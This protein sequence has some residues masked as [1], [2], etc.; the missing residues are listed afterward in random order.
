MRTP[1]S[2]SLAT[3]P[4]RL[5]SAFCVVAFV[6]SLFAARLVQLQG[7]DENDYAAM[8]RATG[9]ETITLEAPRAPIY[10]RFGN[11]LAES[12]DALKL[13]ADPT[14][15]RAHA[16]TIGAVLHRRLGADYIDTVALLRTPNTRYIELARHLLPQAATATV[17]R[18][19]HLNL[20]GVYTAHDT[21]RVYPAGDVAA[22]ILGFVNTKGD[23]SAGI[24][25]AL[26]RQLHG[27]DGEA[28]YQVEQGQILPLAS[29]TVVQP[30]EGTGVRLT[31]DE[32]LQFLAQRR[33]A[34]AVQ[35]AN[36]DSGVAVVMDTR[37]SQ[38]LALAD[39]PTYNA[40]DGAPAKA[41]WNSAGAYHSYEPGSVQKVMTFSALING[42]YVTPRTKVVVPPSL[43]VPNAK[44][45]GDYFTH[46]TLHLTTAGI[47][48]LSS[49]IGTVRS[50]A[51]MPNREL[52]SYL[53]KFGLGTAPQVGLQGVSAGTLGNPDTW[54][55]RTRDTID[56]G[57]SITVTALQMTTAISAVANGGI[58]TAPS[59][60]EGSV[61]SDG[62]FSSAPAPARHRVISAASAHSVMEMMRTVVGPDGT[63]GHDAVP[64]YSVAGK[65]GTAQRLVPSC[66]CY[67]GTTVSFGGF[68]PTSDP[69]FAI[70]VVIQNPRVAGAGGGG[71]AGPVFKDLMIDTLLKYGVPPGPKPGPFLPI[72]W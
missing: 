38:V 20:P 13:I 27:K 35:G 12:V 57:Q 31:L 34:E 48:A 54:A 19:N 68:A 28:T 55:P 14:Y 39:Y 6:V 2:I 58:Y 46:G 15:T 41:L 18:L 30:V 53:K 10:D 33:L 44:P 64:G 62:S 49:N 17:S 63:A 36:A 56:F 29:S 7:I 23:G 59:L 61:S 4:F 50:A 32:D 51:A 40:N 43:P 69:R 22:S 3:G 71:T 16:T 52:Y 8:A 26:N 21:R 66:S 65:T 11:K 5:W 67:R 24:E 37:T 42:G 70:Y 60:V 25:A 45:I 9:A 72:S 47:V 1:R